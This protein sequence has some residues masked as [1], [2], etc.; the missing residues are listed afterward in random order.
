[1]TDN[2]TPNSTAS[3]GNSRFEAISALVDGEF[4]NDT[5]SLLN[6]AVCEKDCKDAWQRYHL[7]RDVLQRDYHPALGADFASK[8]SQSL[9]DEFD[10]S[11]GA[12]SNVM[13]FVDKTH[14]SKARRTL[15]RKTAWLPVAGL[16]LAASVAAAG[17]MA[18]QLNKSQAGFES[19]P[20][21]VA[22]STSAD[23]NNI[24]DPGQSVHVSDASGQVAY[25][26]EPGT[27]WVVATSAQRDAAVEQRLNSLLLN[28]L[29]DSA[30][31]RV[32]GMMAHSRVVAYD[33]SGPVN[34][35]F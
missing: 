3:D 20:V 34:E 12:G 23:T 14:R 33:S 7:V 17:F 5:E 8:V 29:E 4:S 26:R 31:G 1:M 27:R 9:D 35:S 28:H 11:S 15:G 16:G 10:L 13:S 18:W 6:S 25:Q 22:Q 2:N 30:M 19:S 24:S 32:Q 21:A